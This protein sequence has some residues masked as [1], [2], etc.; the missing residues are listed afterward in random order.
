M[1]DYEGRFVSLEHGWLT[2][3]DEALLQYGDE[4]ERT[5]RISDKAARKLKDA[6]S[7]DRIRL[8]MEFNNYTVVKA[9]L[10]SGSLEERV[11]LLEAA[12]AAAGIEVPKG[13]R[14]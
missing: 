14:G 9:S 13:S 4:S 1:G 2:W 3:R 5:D 11:D 8:T 7:G 10:Y 12:L 6:S